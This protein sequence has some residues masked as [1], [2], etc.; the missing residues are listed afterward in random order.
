MLYTMYKAPGIGLAAP[1]VGISQRLFVMDIDFTREKVLRPDGTSE[2]RYENL[3]L[4]FLSIL[5]F[6][7]KAERFSTRKGA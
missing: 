4:K 5:S 2:Y 3:I 7:I 6:A 1:Q